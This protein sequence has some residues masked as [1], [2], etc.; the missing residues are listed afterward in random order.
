MDALVAEAEAQRRQQQQQREEKQHELEKQQQQRQ[1]VKAE[2]QQQQQLEQQQ[3]AGAQASPTA[4][5]AARSQLA[6]AARPRESPQLSGSGLT[7]A[8]NGED[9]ANEGGL[10]GSNS[11]SSLAS[12]LAAPSSP[13]RAPLFPSLGSGGSFGNLQFGN[14]LGGQQEPPRRPELWNRRQPTGDD[15]PEDGVDQAQTGLEAAERKALDAATS[16]HEKYRDYLRDHFDDLV[17]NIPSSPGDV[18]F[19]NS[20]IS[21]S[22]R[23]RPAVSRL[24]QTQRGVIPDGRRRVIGLI[25]DEIMLLH[26]HPTIAHPERPARILCVMKTFELTGLIA[27]MNHLASVDAEPADLLK[28]HLQKHLD[29]VDSLRDP[30]VRQVEHPRLELQSAFANE[31]TAAASYRT[32][33]GVMELVKAVIDGRVKNGLAI[34]RPPGHHA[35]DACIK[36]F[37]VFN[38]I[39]IAAAYAAETMR[40]DDADGDMDCCGDNATARAPVAPKPLKTSAS[41]NSVGGDSTGSGNGNSNGVH[42]ADRPRSQTRQREA[43]MDD[44]ETGAARGA[45]GARHNSDSRTLRKKAKRVATNYRPT[46]RPARVLIVDWDVHHGNGTQTAFDKDPNVLV[47]SVHRW[48]LGRFYPGGPGGGPDHVGSGAGFGRNINIGWNGI[49]PFGDAEYLAAWQHVL[50]PAARHFNPDIVLVS[51]GFDAALGD[52]LGGCA[53]TPE[54]YGALLH[55]LMSLANARIILALEGGY[56]LQ[57]LSESH[58]VCAAVLMGA[59]PPPLTQPLKPPSE[60]GIAAIAATLRAHRMAYWH[61]LEVGDAVIQRQLAWIAGSVDLLRMVTLGEEFHR[62][63]MAYVTGA[64][65]RGE[66]IDGPRK[67]NV[68]RQPG[69]DEEDDDD[70]DDKSGSAP[71][72]AAQVASDMDH[73][74]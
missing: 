14:L 26:G 50:M 12:S 36:G 32:A 11:S 62:S 65:R 68:R 53:I 13:L 70:D 60:Q 7:T 52:P 16:A 40:P 58:L 31:H 18:T 49:G 8:Q 37:C 47:F 22:A 55:E 57:A 34:V 24:M 28:I 23:R 73:D 10:K 72:Q 3:A 19:I 46:K 43:S 2:Q 25:F 1:E 4:A 39:A 27:R 59:P 63:H 17:E 64:G 5:T 29:A 51:A 15:Q 54:G 20:S 67:P 69:G 33:G 38:N 44:R 30:N 9:E 56:S 71:G 74:L 41:S 48:D 6:A 66:F 45:S 21:P 42:D 35:E 61:A